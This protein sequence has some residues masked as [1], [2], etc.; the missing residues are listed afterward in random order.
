MATAQPKRGSFAEGV[1]RRSAFCTLAVAVLFSA[2]AAGQILRFPGPIQEYRPSI[3]LPVADGTVKEEID[4][5]RQFFASGD[6]GEGARVVRRLLAYRKRG[7]IQVDENRYVSPELV[8]RRFIKSL[9]AE[10]RRAFVRQFGSVARRLEASR[11]ED[12]GAELRFLA[13]E[14]PL[15]PEGRRAAFLLASRCLEDGDA[16]SALDWLDLLSATGP[17]REKAEEREEIA[18]KVLAYVLLGDRSEAEKL[19]SASVPLNAQLGAKLTRLSEDFARTGPLW[20]KPR[21]RG[22]FG[23][24]PL[25]RAP[26]RRGS[27]RWRTASVL[28]RAGEGLDLDQPPRSYTLPFAERLYAVVD[29][30]LYVFHDGSG[31]LIAVRRIPSTLAPYEVDPQVERSIPALLADDR[32]VA[33]SFTVQVETPDSFWNFAITEP[34]PFRRLVVFDRRSLRVVWRSDKVEQLKRLNVVGEPLLRDDILYLGGWT[35]EGFINIYIAAVEFATGRVLWKRL[36][37]GGQVPTTMFGEMAVEPYGVALASTGK[38]LVV[39]THMGVLV[40]M[41]RYDGRIRWASTYRMRPLPAVPRRTGFFPQWWESTWEDNPVFIRGKT[42]YAAP[43]D[44]DLLLKLDVA[45]GR[46]LGSLKSVRSSRMPYLIG[47]RNDKLY[48]AGPMGLEAISPELKARRVFL[49]GGSLIGRPALTRDGIYYCISGALRFFD[50]ATGRSLNVAQWP[51]QMDVYNAGNVFVADGKV[52][53][54]SPRCVS[55]YKASS[56]SPPLGGAP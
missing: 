19:L 30:E 22:I 6:F 53:I 9:S 52:Y 16:L 45:T 14:L 35:K 43:R 11:K 55:S 33:G 50:F 23:C 3:R 47:W 42:V 25:E 39:A 12:G 20:G 18:L 48:R 10:G 7:L 46:V 49:A 32:F 28:Q 41:D 38:F 40:C 1:I 4:R 8:V 24:M 37:C 44:S 36:V 31:K 34:I 2:R 5:A 13:R 15:T 27:I 26:F 54:T 21:H 51:P 17:A 29:D 56:D